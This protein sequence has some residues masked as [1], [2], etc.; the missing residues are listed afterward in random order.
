[1]AV[2]TLPALQVHSAN[3]ICAVC[4]IALTL[5]M[6]GVFFENR[7]WRVTIFFVVLSCAT[8]QLGA[9]FYLAILLVLLLV[10]RTPGF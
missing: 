8:Y 6:L 4:A 7:S 9:F 2:F 1:M 10:E 5:S 3:T